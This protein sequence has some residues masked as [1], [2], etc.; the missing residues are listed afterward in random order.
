VALKYTVGGLTLATAII[1]G[2]SRHVKPAEKT[3]QHATALLQY[4][5]MI[6]TITTCLSLPQ[7]MREQPEVFIRDIEA[8]MKMWNEK[9]ALPPPHVITSFEKRYGE[10]DKILYDRTLLDIIDEINNPRTS[11]RDMFRMTRPSPIVSPALSPTP[12]DKKGNSTYA[13]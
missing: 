2:L 12:E 9:Q 7:N 8:K 13:P 10:I 1:T 6:H 11:I 4:Q 5:E 3:Q